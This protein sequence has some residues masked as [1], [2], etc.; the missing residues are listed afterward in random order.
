VPRHNQVRWLSYFDNGEE[1]ESW[2]VCFDYKV[3]EWSVDRLDSLA[4]AAVDIHTFARGSADETF[5]VATATGEVYD[6][7]PSLAADG[8]AFYSMKLVTPWIRLA[9]VAQGWQRVRKV[10]L[11]GRKP[12]QPLI[13][14]LLVEYA[15][16]YD[17]AWTTLATFT[18]A[19]LTAANAVQGD[20]FQVQAWLPGDKQRCESIRLRI[21]DVENEGLGSGYQFR[22]SSIVLEAGIKRG[23]AKL[24]EGAQR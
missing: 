23:V 10:S 11:L 17:D 1:F 20:R 24:V 5:T 13:P 2:L 3:G 8:G 18:Q 14:D 12:N 4:S 16:N 22:L 15:Q 6:E 9:T 21:S 19:E 7:D